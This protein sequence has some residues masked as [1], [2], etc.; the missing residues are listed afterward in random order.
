[1]VPLPISNNKLEG[2]QQHTKQDK[3]DALSSIGVIFGEGLV[4]TLLEDWV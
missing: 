4:Y 3:D 1:M 2:K